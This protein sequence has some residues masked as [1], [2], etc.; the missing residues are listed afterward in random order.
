MGKI[1]EIIYFDKPYLR[2]NTDEMVEFA[3][4]RLKELNLR[5]VVI[6]WET[7]YTF[8]KFLEAAE[9]HGLKDKLNIVVVTNPKG[10]ILKGRHVSIDD[11]TRAKLEGIGVKVCYLRDYFQIGEPFDETRPSDYKER[12]NILRAFGV[13]PYVR[14]LD[15]AV[16][17]DLSLLT[18]ISQ[19]F[20]VCVGITV[21]ATKNGLIP[22]GEYVLALGGISTGLI[23]RASSDARRC[24][25][26]EIL[27]YD[28]DWKAEDPYANMREHL[29][30]MGKD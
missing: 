20:R 6:A 30:K 25:V 12:L 17:T 23:L 14:P 8:W 18:I 21:L 11:E 29:E 5:T 22:E 15:L 3:A 16:G 7:G 26:K 24:L 10:A 9:R 4:K 1:K 28:R 27:G 2:T 19:G 13:S